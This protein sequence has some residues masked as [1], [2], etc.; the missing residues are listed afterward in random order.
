M[1]TSPPHSS[2]VHP[3]SA[4]GIASESTPHTTKVRLTKTTMGSFNRWRQY[5]WGSVY[6]LFKIQ[7]RWAWHEPPLTLL[8]LLCGTGA[9][10]EKRAACF[11]EALPGI[12]LALSRS[13]LALL[14]AGVDGRGYDSPT[15]SRRWADVA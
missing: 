3:P 11:G 1:R 7:P 5:T 9:M 4:K 10:A 12:L 8:H 14:V 2:P 13:V 15:N 6:A